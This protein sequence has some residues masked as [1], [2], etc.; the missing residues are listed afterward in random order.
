MGDIAGWLQFISGAVDASLYP[1]L[2]LSYFKAASGLGGL[3][4]WA[5]WGIK[6][7]FIT[8]MFALNLSGIGNVGHGSVGFMLL[9]LAPFVVV[10]CI[11]FSG[12]FTGTTLL[13]WEFNSA[14]WY[15]LK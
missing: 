8:A 6:A 10:T 9:L 1:A 12:A 4:V 7:T 15:C 5:D 14:N 3:E 2:F 11:A 13:G